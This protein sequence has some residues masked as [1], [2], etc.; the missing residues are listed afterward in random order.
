MPIRPRRARASASSSS[1]AKSMPAT[2][3]SPPLARS[4]PESTA[5]SDDLPDPDGPRMARLSPRP[6]SR[7]MPSQDVGPR[8]AFAEGQGDIARGDDDIAIALRAP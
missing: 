7:S 2:R 4:R 5:I 1:A 8:L 6:M 3:T